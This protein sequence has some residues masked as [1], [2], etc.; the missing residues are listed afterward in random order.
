MRPPVRTLF[1]TKQNLVG[2][3]ILCWSSIVHAY[4]SYIKR[5]FWNIL[6]AH[7]MSLWTKC[8]FF[9][10]SFCCSS[11][12]HHLKVL[13]ATTSCME[14]FF[15]TDVYSCHIIPLEIECSFCFLRWP[16]ELH[17]REIHVTICFIWIKTDYNIVYTMS[18]LLWQ[19]ECGFW[20]QCFSLCY[21]YCKKVMLTNLFFKIKSHQSM[22]VFSMALS[23]FSLC[24][25]SF[26]SFFFCLCATISWLLILLY[27]HARPAFHHK[28]SLHNWICVSLSSV[29]TYCNH[30][31][32]MVDFAV[33][34][35]Y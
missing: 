15:S 9:K 22:L 23:H 16:T 31:L 4:C 17:F 2:W 3:F 32:I 30:R 29:P 20:K 5:G 14:T 7:S 1:L 34:C 11:I 12:C 10:S 18:S 27:W 28:H 25:C 21:M 33:P 24:L 6:Q 19:F 13:G 26:F 8:F 35:C